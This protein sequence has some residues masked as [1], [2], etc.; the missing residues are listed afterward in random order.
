MCPGFVVNLWQGSFTGHTHYFVVINVHS[1]S[2][3]LTNRKKPKTNSL[4]RGS[5]SLN[6]TAWHHALTPCWPKSKQL[7]GKAFPPIALLS[8]NW[9]T[10]NQSHY[11]WSPP[12]S[13]IF[14]PSG[15]SSKMVGRGYMQMDMWR[16]QQQSRKSILCKTLK[17][18]VDGIMRASCPLEKLSSFGNLTNLKRCMLYHYS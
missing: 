13:L 7:M 15:Q 4:R 1:N 17:I 11:S 8:T 14:S 12:D 16:G 3:V 6:E 9:T 5:L 2:H 10:V 18:D